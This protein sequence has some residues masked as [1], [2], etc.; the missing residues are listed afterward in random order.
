MS[1]S[2]GREIDHWRMSLT[3]H[4]NRACRYRVPPQTGAAATVDRFGVCV[5]TGTL[6]G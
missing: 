1:D 3:D 6:N 5:P 4:G 2:C